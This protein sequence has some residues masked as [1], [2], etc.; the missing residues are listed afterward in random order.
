MAQASANRVR[1]SI[2]I[3]LVA[4]CAAIICVLSP[5]RTTS[6]DTVPARLGG[7][8]LRCSGGFDLST[9]D[10]IHAETARSR[11]YYYMHADPS[12]EFS[13]AFGPAPAVLM[14]AALPDF[15]P[16]KSIEDR[17]LRERERAAAA[18]MLALACGLLVVA[19]R[20]RSG[21]RASLLAGITATLS[22]AGA[23]TLG[24]G[25]WQATVALPVVLAALASWAWI[26][27]HPRLAILPPGLCLLAAMLRP[28]IGP[29]MLG[30][31]L[32]WAA[33]RPQRRVWLV[34]SAIAAVLV[35]PLIVWNGIHLNSPLPLGQIESNRLFANQV[36]VLSP[37]HIGVGLAGLACSPARGLLWFAPVALFG[38]WQ[39]LSQPAWP[40]RLIAIGV[41]LQWFVM[42]MFFKWHGGMAFGPRLLAE[43]TWVAIWLAFA[44]RERTARS[45]KVL[46]A[47]VIVTIVVGQLG[48]WGF[49]SEQWET[50]RL[51]DI[52][53][54]ALW[55]FVD[56][57]VAAI[58][59][60][61]PNRTTEDS[62]PRV[63]LE[64]TNGQI[65][66]R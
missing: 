6:G 54:A 62:P 63:E 30:V 48:L 24:Q 46:A 51:P 52:H 43:A 19:T 59:S 21:R 65:V 61:P 44:A 55:D 57:P 5:L 39:G 14:A 49:R 34:A 8:V 1:A 13:S 4:C 27:R 60:S 32:A 38:I 45:R 29:L 66:T 42:A 22:F 9:I 10:W 33:R 12:G 50:R 15:G 17:T 47:T 16:G 31:G 53:P 35:L 26:E 18:V 40:T 64:C 37:R 56:S 3:G 58:F 36:F 28:T 25:L 23:A 11:M 2:A 41:L 7:A 20:A